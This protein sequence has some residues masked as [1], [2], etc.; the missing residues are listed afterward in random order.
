MTTIDPTRSGLE[1][2]LVSDRKLEIREFD[3]PEEQRYRMPADLPDDDGVAGARADR[4]SRA[5]DRPERTP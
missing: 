5:L 4:S 2:V 3:M 1:A